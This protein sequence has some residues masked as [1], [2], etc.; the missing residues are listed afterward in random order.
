MADLGAGAHTRHNVP[1]TFP[2][3]SFGGFSVLPS[4]GNATEAV[5]TG[6]AAVPVAD[7]RPTTPESAT[8]RFLRKPH[9]PLLRPLSL[10]A[11]A[12]QLQP[13]LKGDDDRPALAETPPPTN[14]SHSASLFPSVAS[15][16][17]PQFHLPNGGE[18]PLLRVAAPR[19]PEPQ[20]IG[21]SSPPSSTK[22]TPIV[23]TLTEADLQTQLVMLSGLQRE[24]EAARQEGSLLAAQA[25]QYAEMNKRL[26]QEVDRLRKQETV[27]RQRETELVLAVET[28]HQHILMLQEQVEVLQLRLENV[29]VHFQ[30]ELD[31][32]RAAIS[33]ER[34]G[35]RERYEQAVES[36]RKEYQ[37]RERE[38]IRDKVEAIE[39]LRDQV[40]ALHEQEAL[41]E[42][43]TGFPAPR[44]LD[45]MPH[46]GEA[47]A[48]FD[49]FAA[50]SSRVI[51]EGNDS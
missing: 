14:S 24:L 18:L 36:L 17:T 29:P 16:E 45:F 51:R 8:L 12:P 28:D 7:T 15:A 40:R 19:T 26:Q 25:S 33:R 44:A 42:H 5:L 13:E 11:P 50:G 10:F 22:R 39:A 32:L 35:E 47:G 43:S 34:A 1:V 9:S 49:T 30:T 21:S 46:G 48:P 4:S 2:G 31:L 23:Y 38:I 37:E 6:S 20:L 3:S 41:L 27:W